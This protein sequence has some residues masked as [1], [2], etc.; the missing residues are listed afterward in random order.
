MPEYSL[1]RNLSLGPNFYIRDENI[2]NPFYTGRLN[3]SEPPILIY[4]NRAAQC[5]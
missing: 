1:P 2:T 4:L 3:Y 5:S